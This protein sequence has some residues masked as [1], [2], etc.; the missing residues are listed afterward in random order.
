[1]IDSDGVVM[2]C[3]LPHDVRANEACAADKENSHSS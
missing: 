1:M 2:P 3:D